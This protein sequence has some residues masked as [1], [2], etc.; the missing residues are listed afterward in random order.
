MDLLRSSLG[1]AGDA[2]T[3]HFGKNYISFGNAPQ[4]QVWPERLWGKGFQEGGEVGSDDIMSHLQGLQRNWKQY[5]GDIQTESGDLRYGPKGMFTQAGLAEKF[6]F[7]LESA[8]FDTLYGQ[9][10]DARMGIDISIPDSDQPIKYIRSGPSSDK[11]A[12]LFGIQESAKSEL[13]RQHPGTRETFSTKLG[14]DY[15]EAI[16]AEEAGFSKMDPME[17]LDYEMDQYRKVQEPKQSDAERRM[18]M[19]ALGFTDDAEYDRFLKFK[20]KYGYQ[21]GGHVPQ[22]QMGGLIQYRKGY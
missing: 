9:P 12:E 15:S 10:G 21:L 17:R 1:G 2:L 3:R 16:A 22:Y 18:K 19:K 8:Q 4:G 6:D 7:P 20:E 14:G 11:F 13:E 5:Q